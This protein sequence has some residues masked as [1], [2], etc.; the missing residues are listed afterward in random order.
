MTHDESR[1]GAADQLAAIATAP[2]LSR[3]A[4]VRERAAGLATLA[5]LYAGLVVAMECGLPRPAGIAV[6]VAALALLLAWNNHH[7]GAARRRPQTRVENAAR[8]A[9]VCL[10]ALPGV[11]LVFDEG[12]GTLVAHLV[13][14][15]VPTAAAAVYLVLRWKR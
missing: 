2:D 14:A 6:F 15:A 13:A 10:L 7:D 1:P 8:F 12:P 5:A 4:S 11:D 3:P 9:A